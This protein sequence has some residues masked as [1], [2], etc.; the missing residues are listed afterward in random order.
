MTKL[1]ETQQAQSNKGEKLRWT[2][3]SAEAA[4]NLL[5]SL[6]S[7]QNWNQPFESLNNPNIKVNNINIILSHDLWSC[8]DPEAL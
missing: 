2:L 5:V 4:L 7:Q 1:T 6:M 3:S 8:F